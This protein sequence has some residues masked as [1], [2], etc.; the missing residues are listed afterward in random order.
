MVRFLRSGLALPIHKSGPTSDPN[1]YRPISLTSTCCRVI[2]RI[3]N[4]EILNYL[5]KYNLISQQ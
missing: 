2:E 5:L 1:N 3:I 4:K